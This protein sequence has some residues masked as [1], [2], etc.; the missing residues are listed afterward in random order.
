VG[1]KAGGEATRGE[2][3][4]EGEEERFQAAV[5]EGGGGVLGGAVERWCV[6]EGGRR[7]GRVRD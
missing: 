2:G 6:G 3:P 4:M 7:G 5:D 1:S